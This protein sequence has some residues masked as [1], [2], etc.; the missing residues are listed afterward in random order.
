[1]QSRAFDAAFNGTPLLSGEWTSRVNRP[2][3]KGR[4]HA[5]PLPGR[6]GDQVD[7]NGRAENVQEG[8][9]RPG[10]PVGVRGVGLLKAVSF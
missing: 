7:G 5:R 2:D 10:C 4:A 3:R 1:M 9:D 8:S 6:L